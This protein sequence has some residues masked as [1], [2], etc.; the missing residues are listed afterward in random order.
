[1]GASTRSRRVE[2]DASPRRPPPPATWRRGSREGEF[3][4]ADVDLGVV[5]GEASER[6]GL[7][8][9]GRRAHEPE[10][11]L[12]LGARASDFAASAASPAASSASRALSRKT[13]PAGVSATP[14]ASVRATESRLRTR[15]AR[16]PARS[17]AAR[18]RASQPRGSAGPHRRWRRG[19]GDVPLERNGCPPGWRSLAARYRLNVEC[20]VRGGAAARSSGSRTRGGLMRGRSGRASCSS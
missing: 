5:L 3:A 18:C 17:Q 7:S 14:R 11:D 15:A 12:A 19:I 13:S 9:A 20:A 10:L 4:V 6:P 2:A 8:R 1:M 16:S